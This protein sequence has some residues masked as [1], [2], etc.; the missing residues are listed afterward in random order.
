VVIVGGID[1]R[2]RSVILYALVGRRLDDVIELHG[3]N[4]Q[5]AVALADVLHHEPGLA[6]E[7]YVAVQ[8]GCCLRRP[9][10]R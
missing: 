9:F 8:A 4:A 6:T 10:L 3:S 2:A 1:I 5:V 7:L